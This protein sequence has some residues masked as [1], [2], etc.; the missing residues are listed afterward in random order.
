MPGIAL[1]YFGGESCR[2][3]SIDE[4]RL[5]LSLII[6]GWWIAAYLLKYSRLLEYYIIKIIH[7]MCVY[8]IRYN[9]KIPVDLLHVLWH[10]KKVS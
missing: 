10:I 5:A 3:E 7:I 2:Q 9:A 8:K 6:D 1:K 4:T